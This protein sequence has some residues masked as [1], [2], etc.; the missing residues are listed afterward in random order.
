MLRHD[1]DSE[2]EQDNTNDDHS[3]DQS[4]LRKAISVLEKVF[5]KNHS[6]DD[7]ELKDVGLNNRSH[8]A[9]KT[10]HH[11]LHRT[12]KPTEN[13][14]KNERSQKEITAELKRRSVSRNF[15]TQKCQDNS[16]Q[17]KNVKKPPDGVLTELRVNTGPKQRTLTSMLGSD[18]NRETKNAPL[19]VK[20]SLC[21]VITRLPKQ[22]VVSGKVQ[23]GKIA[24]KTILIM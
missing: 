20:P 1:V 14:K 5:G 18:L 16:K 10:H 3:T 7:P 6:N 19:T 2:G 21:F 24:Y 11:S 9:S 15:S 8:D 4:Y 17:D 22:F 12:D 13:K 23:I